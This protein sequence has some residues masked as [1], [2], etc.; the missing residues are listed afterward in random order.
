MQTVSGTHSPPGQQKVSYTHSV[1][2]TRLHGIDTFLHGSDSGHEVIS[3]S[4]G[5]PDGESDKQAKSR[6]ENVLLKQ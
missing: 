3:R 6:Q 2:L 1:S 4:D 5:V